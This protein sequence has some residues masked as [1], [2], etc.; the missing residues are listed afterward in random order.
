MVARATSKSSSLRATIPEQI[1]K[2]MGLEAGDVLDWELV[3]EG[4]RN[5]VR[6]RKLE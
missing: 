6:V 2:Q 4:K 3:S 1:A 5:I